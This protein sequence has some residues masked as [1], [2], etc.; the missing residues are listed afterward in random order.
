MTVITSAEVHVAQVFP[1]HMTAAQVGEVF[2]LSAR[3]I[4]GM[5]LRGEI[6]AHRIGGAW[7]FNP[8]ELRKWYPTTANR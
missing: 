5:A 7:R 4:T 2:G 3:S 8:D 1:P 6:P